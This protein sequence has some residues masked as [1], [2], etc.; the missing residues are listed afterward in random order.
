MSK[1]AAH[2]EEII[3]P[4]LEDLNYELVDV[5]YVKEDYTIIY[6]LQLIKTVALI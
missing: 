6:V 1:V 2:V 3:Q 5:E 4:I